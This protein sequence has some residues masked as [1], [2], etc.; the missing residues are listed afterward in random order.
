MGLFILGI[1]L[2]IMYATINIEGKMEREQ[3]VQ[4]A[5]KG[6]DMVALGAAPQGYKPPKLMMHKDGAVPT[7]YKTPEQLKPQKEQKPVKSS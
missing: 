4:L 2:A 6:H 3:V 5:V 7:G 1:G